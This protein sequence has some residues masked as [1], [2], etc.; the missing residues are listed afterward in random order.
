MLFILTS[1]HLCLIVTGQ[2]LLR[3]T[4]ATLGISS[5]KRF[6]I[7][8]QRLT[9]PL[10]LVVRKVRRVDFRKSTSPDV[11]VSRC[12]FQRK[13]MLFALYCPRL[14][15]MP[16]ID[17][18][19]LCWQWG[20][21]NVAS[22]FYAPIIKRRVKQRWELVLNSTNNIWFASISIMC[23]LSHSKYIWEATK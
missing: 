5:R 22:R 16:F 18:M 2:A 1:C 3:T 11:Y 23:L 7:R 15:Q 19:K 13:I 20:M 17:Q 8:N 6:N 12:S 14:L 4:V 21:G 10:D 9:Q